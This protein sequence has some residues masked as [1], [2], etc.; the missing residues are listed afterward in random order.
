LLATQVINMAIPGSNLIFK[1]SKDE[2]Q[3]GLMETLFIG[4]T[5]QM[6]Y[7]KLKAYTYGTIATVTGMVCTA[8]ADYFVARWTGYNGILDWF[9]AVVI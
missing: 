6:R 2:Q 3:E 7:L 9:F 4:Q 8:T 1:D 5:W